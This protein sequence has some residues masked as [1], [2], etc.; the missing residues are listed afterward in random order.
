MWGK[1]PL[2]G[3]DLRTICAFIDNLRHEEVLARR[4]EF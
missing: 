1:S 4:A 3:A 2:T